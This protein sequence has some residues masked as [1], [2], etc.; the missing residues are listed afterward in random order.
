M[1][2]STAQISELDGVYRPRC[3]DDHRRHGPECIIAVLS[4][5][6]KLVVEDS[7]RDSLL[8]HIKAKIEAED[9]SEEVPKQNMYVMDTYCTHDLDAKTT[10]PETD[11]QNNLKL[12]AAHMHAL[13]IA[14]PVKR[15]SY[16]APALLY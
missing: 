1:R 2:S 3:I 7:E 12:M 10:S 4:K 16:I 15:P 11:V 8:T 6:E 13:G 5:A 9:Q 14:T